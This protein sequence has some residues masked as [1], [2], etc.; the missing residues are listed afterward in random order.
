MSGSLPLCPAGVGAVVTKAK[1]NKKKTK[2]YGVWKYCAA[3]CVL[4]PAFLPHWLRTHTPRAWASSKTAG[5]T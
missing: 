1:G 4:F 5:T 3:R 2:K